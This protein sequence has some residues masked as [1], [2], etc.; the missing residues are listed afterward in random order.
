VTLSSGTTLKAK[1]IGDAGFNIDLALLKVEPE[2]P[3]P[4]V[5]WGDSRKVRVGDAV[6]AIGNPL[7]VGES[8]SAGIVSALNRNIGET[9][10]DDFI[11]TDAAINHGNS[12]GALVDSSGDVIGVNT[13]IFSPTDTGGS[14]GLGFAIPEYDVR[15]VI[16]RLRKFGKLNFGYLG[17]RLQ[18]VTADMADALGMAAP[19]GAIIASVVPDGPGQAVGLK[20]GDVILKLANQTP[21]DTRALRRMIAIAKIGATVPVSIWRDGKTQTVTANIVEWPDE[22]KA[23]ATAAEQRPAT[24]NAEQLGLHL[25]PITD[26][27][28]AR[29]KLAAGVSG[30]LVSDITH[31][32]TASDQG[33]AAGDVIVKV[34]QAPVS[35]PAEVQQGLTDAL[36]Q[37]HH[38]ALLLVQ[39]P[40]AQEWLTLPI[41]SGG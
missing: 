17:V 3:L 23:A 7:G 4:V 38:H 36:A 27:A 9:P 40:G 33:I 30:V 18:D 20:E 12:G 14:I 28:R 41:G 19:H 24:A 11:Q 22:A 21:T 32:S 39:K 5:K 35:T 2:K 31:N 10:Y 26:E 29:F 15:F 25:A 8:V 34:Q 37:D 6:F 1:I 13:A 16:D